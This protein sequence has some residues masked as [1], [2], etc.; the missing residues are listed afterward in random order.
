M[1]QIRKNCDI[2]IVSGGN[3]LIENIF[4]GLPSIAYASSNY[5]NK[6]INQLVEKKISNKNIIF[7]YDKFSK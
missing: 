4:I 7:E 5:E 1:K 3:I 2:G 6:I